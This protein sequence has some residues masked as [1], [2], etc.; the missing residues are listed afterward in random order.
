MFDMIRRL[1]AFLV[2]AS[3]FA[4]SV[5]ASN[6]FSQN[7]RIDKGES[8][9]LDGYEFRYYEVEDNQGMFQTGVVRQ[10]GGTHIT[11]QLIGEELENATGELRKLDEDLS[12][13]IK[14]YSNSYQGEYI[15]I[16]ANS[17]KDIFSETDVSADS[18][19]RVL[20]D[21]G[22]SV[23]FGVEV[24]NTGVVNQ[25]FQLTNTGEG[26]SSSFTY[27][28]YNVS[29]VFVPYGESRNLNVKLNV[30]EN[31][32]TGL[33][34]VDIV[35]ENR[36]RGTDT[37]LLSV[38]EKESQERGEPR[39]DLNLRESYARTNPGEELTVPVSVRNSGRVTLTNVEV[40]VEG[41]DG[42]TTEVTPQN[43]GSLDRYRSGRATLTVEPPEETGQGDYFIDVSASSEQVGIDEPQQIRVNISEKSGLRYIGIILMIASLLALLTVYWRFGRR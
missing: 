43:F 16:Q 13:T 19:Q 24:K 28:G 5:Q 27:Q 10:D 2:L 3:V 6:D 35:A 14:E 23:N 7:F 1:A 15:M 18:P 42:W 22:G 31:T 25:T 9:D 30:A 36:S 37:V 41:P 12:Y 32:S 29:Q 8:V 4:G 33:R 17:S 21:Q 11:E 34:N 20:V 38:L 40:T 39:I 26:I